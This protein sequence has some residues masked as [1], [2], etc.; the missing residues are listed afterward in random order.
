MLSKLLKLLKSSV[1]LVQTTAEK[2]VPRNLMLKT[3]FEPILKNP[4]GQ[5]EPE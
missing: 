2:V 4:K 3:S 1:F 5:L